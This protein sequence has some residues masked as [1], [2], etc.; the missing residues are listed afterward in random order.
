M[1]LFKK[2]YF[3]RISLPHYRTQASQ[4]S[5]SLPW[6]V[7]RIPLLSALRG[8]RG[9]LVCSLQKS[10]TQGSYQSTLNQKPLNTFIVMK[11]SFTMDSLKDVKVILCHWDF[12]GKAVLSTTFLSFPINQ[13]YWNHL[14][15]S[16]WHRHY[17]HR[18]LWPFFAFL[19]LWEH[20]TI[21]PMPATS[22][23]PITNVSRI[24]Y[25]KTW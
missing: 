10:E 8:W 3:V 1:Y 19:L 18:I 23:N 2:L 12:M 22:P 20:F 14:K 25:W 7:R 6:I 5:T 17:P 16:V 24:I 15:V 13:H 21:L 4:G 9:F 11:K